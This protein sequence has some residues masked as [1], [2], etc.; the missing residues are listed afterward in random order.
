M[1]TADADLEVGTSRT[2]TLG[3]ETHQLANTVRI[4]HVERVAS[5]QTLLQVG[6][7][8]PALDVVAAEPEGHL[9]QVVGPEGEEVGLLGDLTS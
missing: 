5:K 1:L 6:R 7:H 8:H 4:D 3:A 9:G 2:P